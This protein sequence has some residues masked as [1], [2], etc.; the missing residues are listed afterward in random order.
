MSGEVDL[1]TL[2]GRVTREP[3]S[4]PDERVQVLEAARA[5]NKDRSSE[6]DRMLLDEI[7]RLRADMRDV[8][9]IQRRLSDVFDSLKAAPWY[10]AIFT[11]CQ[12]V[13]GRTVAVVL[14]GGSLRVVPAVDTI[15]LTRLNIGDEVL[16]GNE[17][18][19]VVARSSA[20][21]FRSGETAVFDRSTSDGRIVIKSRDEEVVVDVGG[22]LRSVDL[23]AG[24][25]VRWDRAVWLAYEKLDAPGAHALFLED[26]PT[27]SFEQVGGLDAIVDR[28]QRTISLHTDH[29][30][31]VR[32]YRLRK[33][34]SV[35]FS[36][37][38]GNGKTLLA[39][40][41]AN[42]LG[43]ISPSGRA[44]F[45]HIKPG[46][47]HSM[48]YSASEANY[49]E[50]FR[51]AREAGELEPEIP[52]VMFFDE[53]DAV[54]YAR[55]AS[56][57][58]VDDR[59]QTA[60]MAELDGL[61]TRGNILVV[62]ATNRKEAIDPALLRPGRLG[63]L[64]LEIPRP[65][66]HGARSIFSR[67][68]AADLPYFSDE[69]GNRGAARRSIIDAALARIYGHGPE[70]RLATVT[71]RDGKQRPV[72]A[73][74]VI[75]GA[76]IAKVVGE[77]VEHACLREKETGEEGIRESDVLQAVSE[78]CSRAAG[79]L[80]PA[81]CRV[82]LDDLPQD[83]DVVRVEPVRPRVVPERYLSPVA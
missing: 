37:P 28:L 45:M 48:W 12:Q 16:L 47:L 61:E 40:A 81:N 29:P 53:V 22:P 83:V 41:L 10:P 23:H 73:R 14:V 31:L 60:L 13:A 9:Q 54:G 20:P 26:M 4:D 70:T 68:L 49:R 78:E 69:H 74:D 1:H 36:G 6:I 77:A 44:R 52:V 11:G 72:A 46:A 24:D 71:F 19:L 58:Q 39:R 80:T 51:V 25:R 27:E 30:G 2:L 65:N 21:S 5:G 8:R 66:R 59:V 62:A 34:S 32:K 64:V 75:T 67:Y 7:L 63:D 55:G 33:C 50:A 56:H 76:S 15:D 42:W 38:P 17:Q 82:H 57:M 18:N 43:Q 79:V 35:L 3:G